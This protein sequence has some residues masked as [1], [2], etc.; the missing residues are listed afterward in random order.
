MRTQGVRLPKPPMPP[1]MMVQG[2]R[3]ASIH[4][5]IQPCWKA[6]SF[7]VVMRCISA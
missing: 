1:L 6:M 3:M 7:S 5:A 2:Q 4:M